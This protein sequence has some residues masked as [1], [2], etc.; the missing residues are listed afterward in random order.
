MNM[1]ALVDGQPKLLN[2]KLLSCFLSHRREVLTR[3][4]YTNCARR[5][6]AATCWKAWRWRSPT[7]TT[8]S[9]SS[10]LA[11]S[12]DREE[13]LMNARLGFV[14][15]ARN[16]VARRDGKCPAASRSVPSGRPAPTYG[17]QPDGLYRLS[18]T[19]AQ[20]ILQ[21]RLQRLTGSGAGQDRRRVQGSDGA[22]SPTC[23]TSWRVRN[24]LRRSS[25]TNC[26]AEGRIRRRWRRRSH[27]T[28]RHRARHRR[29]DHA[30]GHGRDH[31]AHRL[32]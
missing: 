29:P 22:R 31:V 7:S 6:N 30:A 9:R 12:A 2:L 10:R 20:E 23:S 3:R 25:S 8:S 32:L 19:Q 5:A 13:E 21:M 15:G 26:V 27:R 18:D 17:M 24:A 1:V 11:D 4:T 14:A 28:E 16:A